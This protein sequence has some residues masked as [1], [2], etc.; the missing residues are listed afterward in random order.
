LAADYI[1]CFSPKNNCKDRII[2][3][4]DNTKSNLKIAIFSFTNKEIADSVIRAH[5]RHVDVKLIMDSQQSNGVGTQF[6]FLKELGI[7]VKVDNT[8]G[9]M[10]NKYIISDDKKI[11]TGSYNFTINADKRNFE[12][13]MIS[14][15]LELIEIYVKNF[16][17]MWNKF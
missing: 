16:N 9:Y 6:Q 4:I 13:F 10:H 3:L 1:V 5:T 2:T 8:S 17:S 7:P 15:D 11:L 12:N 14:D